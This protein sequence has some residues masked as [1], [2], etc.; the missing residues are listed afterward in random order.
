METTGRWLNIVG[1]NIVHFFPDY[2]SQFSGAMCSYS[3]T[4]RA[5]DGGRHCSRCEKAIIADQ[6]RREKELIA[7]AGI[8]EKIRNMSNSAALD[9][10]L[11]LTGDAASDMGIYSHDES[12]EREELEANIRHRLT[13][14]IHGV[15]E[16]LS[17]PIGEIKK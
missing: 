5:G 7:R 12:V 16:I 10:L 4:P 13:Y 15:A 6:K 11:E 17:E 2:R 9:R 14:Y 3:V 1:S 8:I